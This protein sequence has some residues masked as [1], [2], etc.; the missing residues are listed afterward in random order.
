VIV[1]SG[2]TSGGPIRLQ[3]LEP[4]VRGLILDGDG[5]LWKDAEPIGDLAA[6]FAVI[7]RMHLAV[8]VATNNAMK[9]VDEYLIKLRGFGVTVEPWQIVTAGDAAADTLASAFPR[10]GALFVVGEHGLRQALRERGFEVV[11]DPVRRGEVVAVVVGLDQ[12]FNYE[13]LERASTLVR[14]G[15]PFFG[16]NPDLTYPTPRGLVPGAGAILAAVAAAAGRQ[17][18]VVGKPSPLLFQTA[19]GR[20]QLGADS[21]LVVGDRLETDIAGGQAF[22]ARTALVLSGVSTSAQAA[23]WTPSPTL[24]AASLGQL[25][26]T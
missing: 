11:V 19:A 23:V 18:T 2:T 10:R 13:K 6:I 14:A 12:D 1:G 8:T 26:G 22:G 7:S 16:T 21:L 25:L 15:A 24:V 20:M 5:V 9:T 3:D 4:P 17:P